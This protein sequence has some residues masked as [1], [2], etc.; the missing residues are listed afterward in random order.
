MFNGHGKC[1][2]TKQQECAAPRREGE[3]GAECDSRAGNY[4]V[5]PD[6]SPKVPEG[7]E[8]SRSADVNKVI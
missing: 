7:T 1:T 5:L 8:Q 2:G 6:K 3:P 4:A